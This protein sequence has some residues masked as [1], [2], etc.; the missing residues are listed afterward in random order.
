MER[1]CLM[2]FVV[3]G[4]IRGTKSGGRKGLARFSE[5][6]D[7]LMNWISYA[8]GMRVVD[9]TRRGLFFNVRRDDGALL[10]VR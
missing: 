6:P 7:L 3:T 9:V 2:R 8:V 5:M 4:S 1:T 10:A